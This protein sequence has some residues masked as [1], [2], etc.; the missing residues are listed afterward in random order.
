MIRD[1]RGN[2]RKALTILRENYLSKGKPEVISLY[3][4][5]TTLRRLESVYYR[6]YNKDREYFKAREVISDVL[7]IAMTL[8]G[9]PPNF[10]PF[11]TVST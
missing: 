8:E 2:V 7:L 3:T 11:T 6:L 4:E 5:I 9:L 1:A 10:K